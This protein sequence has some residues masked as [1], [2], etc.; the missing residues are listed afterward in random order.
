M[1]TIYGTQISYGT[2]IGRGFYLPHT[3][4]IVVNPA[5]KIGRNC[6][7]SHNVTIGK[8]HTGD[9]Q[10][11]PTLGNDV[12]VGAGAVILGNIKIGDNAAIGPNSVVIN[13]VPDNVYVGGIP[14]KVISNKGACD[15]LGRDAAKE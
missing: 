15:V 5:T 7:L 4:G 8:V 12:F 2:Q 3:G 9:K 10:G 6:Y 11:V 13:D 14:A 1:Q